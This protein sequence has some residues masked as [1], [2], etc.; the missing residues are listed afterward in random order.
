LQVIEALLVSVHDAGS[1]A[2]QLKIKIAVLE[3]DTDG[4]QWY[5]IRSKLVVV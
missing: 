2:T 5:F 1:K 4:F 3:S